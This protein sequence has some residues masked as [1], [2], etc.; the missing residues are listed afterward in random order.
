MQTCRTARL[1]PLQMHTIYKTPE[2]TFCSCSK[3]TNVLYRAYKIMTSLTKINLLSAFQNFKNCLICYYIRNEHF[4]CQIIAYDASVYG[5][6][7]YEGAI[8]WRNWLKITDSKWWKCSISKDMEWRKQCLMNTNF[9]GVFVIVFT[10]WNSFLH[11][12]NVMNNYKIGKKRA[13]EANY[14]YVIK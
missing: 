13:W 10:V 11:A 5:H 3:Q 9:T 8:L 4:R 7:I 12:N 6:S 1:I 2:N 14:L